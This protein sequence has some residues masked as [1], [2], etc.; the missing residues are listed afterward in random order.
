[1]VVLTLTIVAAGGATA[2]YFTAEA[3][4]RRDRADIVRWEGRA[5]PAARDAASVRSTLRG[6]MSPDQVSATRARLQRDLDA[7]VSPPLPEIVRPAAAAYQAAISETAAA[8]D[9]LGTSKFDE[10]LNRAALAFDEA[11]RTEQVLVC[12][13]ELP[14]CQLSDQGK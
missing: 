5:V 8:L 9:F 6:T 10:A 13:A 4:H 7:I 1:M 11:A 12:R 2:V 14:S 3:Q